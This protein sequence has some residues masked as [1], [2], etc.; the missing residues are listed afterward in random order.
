MN[1][2]SSGEGSKWMAVLPLPGNGP[3][4]S[5]TPLSHIL[6]FEIPNPVIN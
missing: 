3:V 4:P 6:P 2:K 1:Q 5:R